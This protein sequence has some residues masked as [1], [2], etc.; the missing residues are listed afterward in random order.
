MSLVFHK[1][2][3]RVMKKLVKTKAN[4]SKRNGLYKKLA[5][6]D[7]Y[8]AFQSAEEEYQ[9]FI[10]YNNIETPPPLTRYGDDESIISLNREE[11]SLTLPLM[12]KLQRACRPRTAFTDVTDMSSNRTWRRMSM[13]WSSGYER[14]NR[15]QVKIP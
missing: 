14:T 12:L 4:T 10:L 11:S 5:N 15:K 13:S 2:S 1:G 3:I 8:K 9:R 6:C 7:G